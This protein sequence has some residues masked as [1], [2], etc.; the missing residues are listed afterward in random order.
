MQDKI[1]F[2]G[3]CMS[4]TIATLLG[5]ELK[6]VP[7]FWD[8]IDI[9]NPAPGSGALFNDNVNYFLRQHGFKL[10]SLGVDSKNVTEADQNW[11]I[12][13]SKE[14]GVKHLVAGISPRGH[15]HSVIYEHGQLWHDPHPEGGG[16]IPC[17]VE[18]I[19][20]IFGLKRE[21]V[22]EQNPER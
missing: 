14:L 8:G 7:S 10:I 5:L 3:N 19:V 16:V 15:M 13:I 12:N 21:S 1:G 22:E 6:D 18:F 20:P 9:E 17:Q 11:V 4:A 2:G